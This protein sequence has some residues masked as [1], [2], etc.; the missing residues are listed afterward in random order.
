MLY[1]VASS[2]RQFAPCRCP[3]EE[4]MNDRIGGLRVVSVE[5][6]SYARCRHVVLAF[7][8]GTQPQ[9]KDTCMIPLVVTVFKGEMRFWDWEWDKGSSQSLTSYVLRPFHNW[10]RSP[11]SSNGRDARLLV[12]VS[13]QD[14]GSPYGGRGATALP[15][16]AAS[17]DPPALVCAPPR[18]RLSMRR[19]QQAATL[20]PFVVG[21]V[22]GTSII[23]IHVAPPA[24]RSQQDLLSCQF[25]PHFTIFQLLQG[26]LLGLFFSERS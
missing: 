23:R 15:S 11:R 6:R 12:P 22:R 1:L 16:V 20:P 7:R 8:S 25:K 4:C 26:H 2:F 13:R 14:G 3:R 10:W 21:S 5:V 24:R 19:S 17:C 9:Q 18:W